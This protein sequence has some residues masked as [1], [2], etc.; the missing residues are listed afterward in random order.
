MTP[1][2]LDEH[3]RCLPP[4]ID[5]SNKEFYGNGLRI[6]TKND[7][8]IKVLELNHVKNGKVDGDATR[9][10]PEIEAVVE[11]LHEIIIRDESQKNNKNY[12]P[13]TI[14]IISPF[15]SQVEAIKKSLMKAFSDATLE[16]HMVEVGTAHA[17]QGD[18]RD[19]IIMSW[20]I[21]DN[22]FPQSLSFLQKPN[23][24][25]VAVTR[26]KKQCISFVSKDPDSF[27][28]GIMRNYIEH[29]KNYEIQRNLVEQNGYISTYNNDFEKEVAEKL[30]EKGLS[31]KAGYKIAGFKCDLFVADENN[32]SIVVECDGVKD[33]VSSNVSPVKKQLIIERSGLNVIRISY[34]DWLRS[35]SACLMRVINN[36]NP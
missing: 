20:A 24:F 29:I 33:E 31:V 19:I 28:V 4:I 14:G 26:A 35:Q 11:K 16:R 18:E 8:N 25:N 3:F 12:K 21:A 30:T 32:N 36:L 2:L 1:V 23:L 6:M 13:V 9:N 10:I 7:D 27:Q 34:R 22:S 5:F 15:R 17:F